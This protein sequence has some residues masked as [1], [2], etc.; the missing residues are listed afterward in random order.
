MVASP[1][2]SAQARRCSRSGPS[3]FDG[4][5]G[6][7]TGWQNAARRGGGRPAKTG[8]RVGCLGMAWEAGERAAASAGAGRSV[9]S[10]QELPPVCLWRPS[11]LTPAACR[12]QHLLSSPA[13]SS[14]K[15]RAASAACSQQLAAPAQAIVRVAPATPGAAHVCWAL[16]ARQSAAW[17]TASPPAPPPPD[18]RRAAPPGPRRRAATVVRYYGG[19]K[20]GA[21]GLV[22]ATTDCVAQ[23]SSRPTRCPLCAC[24]RCTAPCPTPLEGLVAARSPPWVGGG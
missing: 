16:L 15:E 7:R 23:P 18:A 22:R 17:T 11:A 9:E 5:A 2:A 19:V 13:S 20:L 14:S 3:A 8:G 12:P 10:P 24:R 21:G 1:R 6:R 4:R